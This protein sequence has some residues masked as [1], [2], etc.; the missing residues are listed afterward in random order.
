MVLPY[1]HPI[2]ESHLVPFE[3]AMEVSGISE[4]LVCTVTRQEAEQVG[5]IEINR[6]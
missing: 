4:G 2:E 6:S 1:E 3:I 5:R